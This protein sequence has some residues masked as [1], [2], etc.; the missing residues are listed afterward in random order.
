MAAARRVSANGGDHLEGA[1][2]LAPPRSLPLATAADF[3]SDDETT[4][5]MDLPTAEE[6]ALGKPRARGR[7]TTL[8]SATAGVPS[9]ARRQPDVQVIGAETP[10]KPGE[11]TAP[12]VAP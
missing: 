8:V 1:A 3:D 5:V 4:K 9:S 2:P 11:T 7:A 6:L 10:S 12:V